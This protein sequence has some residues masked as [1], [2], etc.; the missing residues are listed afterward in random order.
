[1]NANTAL[2]KEQVRWAYTKWCEGY[3]LLQIAEALNV[4]KKDNKACN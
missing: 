3:T 2:D 1:M 4:C